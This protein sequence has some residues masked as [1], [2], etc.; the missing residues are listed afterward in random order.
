MC[1]PIEIPVFY[2]QSKTVKMKYFIHINIFSW[3]DANN[4]VQAVV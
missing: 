4:D 3:G 1:L 2:V